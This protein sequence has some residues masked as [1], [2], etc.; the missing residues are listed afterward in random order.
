MWSRTEEQVFAASESHFRPND[1]A[2]VATVKSKFVY[3]THREEPAASGK[4]VAFCEVFETEA[5]GGT[6]LA[7]DWGVSQH[8]NLFL[9][10]VQPADSAAP[11]GKMKVIKA[12]KRPG[13]E[14]QEP[15]T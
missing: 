14:H 11:D 12:V 3:M 10:E 1:H 13:A 5:V 9:D 8:W 6:A 7:A 15:R 2:A 4:W